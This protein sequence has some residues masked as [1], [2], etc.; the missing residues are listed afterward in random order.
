MAKIKQLFLT[1]I[2]VKDVTEPTDVAN[3]F[4]NAFVL[5]GENIFKQTLLQSTMFFIA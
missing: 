4:N 2:G 3:V 1:E 5:I